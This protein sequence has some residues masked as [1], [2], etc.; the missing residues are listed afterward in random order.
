MKTETTVLNVAARRGGSGGAPLPP[1]RLD[2]TSTVTDLVEAVL[3]R[4]LRLMRMRQVRAGSPASATAAGIGAET[5]VIL[6]HEATTRIEEA[7]MLDHA[8]AGA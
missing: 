3:E 7:V 1:A 6:H 4:A 2:G 8:T 5:A